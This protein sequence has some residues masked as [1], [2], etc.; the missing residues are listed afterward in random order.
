[1]IE[2][3]FVINLPTSKNRW[4][5]FEKEELPRTKITVERIDGIDGTPFTNKNDHLLRKGILGCV[6]ANRNVIEVAKTRGY[7]NVLVFEDDA[8]LCENFDA[9]LKKA[10]GELPEDWAILRLHPTTNGQ[11]VITDY[12]ENLH[13]VTGCNGT[14]GWCINAPYY[15]RIIET[16]TREL[17]ERTTDEWGT[18]DK[19]FD[20]ILRENMNA[21]PFYQTKKQLV[22]HADGF[23]DRMGQV[24]N[25]GL[26]RPKTQKTEPLKIA[27]GTGE[28]VIVYAPLHVYYHS[29]K[30]CEILNELN[31]NCTY[32]SNPS[33]NS[34]AL[35]ILYCAFHFQN[36]PKNYI[37][38][39]CEQW[40]SHWMEEKYFDLMRGAVAVWEFSEDNI[41]KYPEDL[42]E[43]VSFVPPGLTNGSKSVKNI[44]VLFYGALN[45]HRHKYLQSLKGSGL[46]I[47]HEQDTFGEQMKAI[48]G[49]SKVVLNLHFHIPGTL[50][51]FRINE[52]LSCGCHVVSERNNLCY[53]P[54][55]YRNLISYGTNS[56]ELAFN[57]KKLL[58]LPFTK[59]ID[60]LDNTKFVKEAMGK[61][62]YFIL[63]DGAH[64]GSNI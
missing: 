19:T 31:Y 18:F 11:P 43:K 33:H 32:T 29:E 17:G 5:Q 44:D 59:N 13:R 7:K 50:E 58:R 21:L 10:I 20:L 15:N 34:D 40:S 49:R 61:I 4:L 3:A 26:S 12:S 16:L 39:Q 35:H 1:M 53:Y 60:E 6:L 24:V 55:Q 22:Y 23:S 42:K 63:A 14:Y 28:R 8:Q 57:I 47:R 41:G 54:E 2:H 51:V 52:A 45:E 36:P 9:E 25:F 37:V 64:S 62:K 48:L 56:S 46:R 27:T 30:L 38:Y